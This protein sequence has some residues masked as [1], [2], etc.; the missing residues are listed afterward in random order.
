MKSLLAALGVYAFIGAVGVADGQ[1][2]PV[3][4][5]P[6]AASKYTID[7]DYSKSPDLKE[8]ADTKLRPALEE[9]Y[10][11]IL[12]DL[13]SEGFVPPQHFTV[14]IADG[15]GAAA[16][17]GTNVMVNALFIRSQ[18]SRGPQNESVGAVVHE[19]VHIAQQYGGR[20]RGAVPGWLTEGI[21]DYIR[22]WKYEPAS[23]RRV[24][25]R[26]GR[27]GKPTSYTDA[28]ATTA[29]FLEFCAKNYDHEI[30]VKLNA[31]G[32]SHTYSPELWTKYTGKSLDDL[33]AEFAQTLKP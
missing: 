8:W 6:A 28:Y 31:V 26:T 29:A 30:V 22:W 13:P 21:A 17:S 16:A 25:R 20:N 19:A 32:R 10:P 23:V 11:I 2:A 12:A 33:W 14:A 7:I 18:L 4:P 1:D 15:E 9:W 24:I 3:K 5:A 27:N